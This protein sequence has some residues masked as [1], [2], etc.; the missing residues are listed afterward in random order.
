[1]LSEVMNEVQKRCNLYYFEV[2]DS[3]DFFF[4]LYGKLPFK[5]NTVL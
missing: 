2:N 3:V 1:M 4:C 5:Y